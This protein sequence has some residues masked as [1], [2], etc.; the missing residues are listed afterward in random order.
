MKLPPIFFISRSCLMFVGP[1]MA[2]S[3]HPM[4]GL[5]IFGLSSNN[6]KWYEMMFIILY[7]IVVL[8]KDIFIS[9]YVDDIVDNDKKGIV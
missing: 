4:H 2:S 9:V 8:L 7:F 3:N 1:Y 5:G 6:L